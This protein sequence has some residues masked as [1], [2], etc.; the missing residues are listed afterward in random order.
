[1]I[2]QSAF[3]EFAGHHGAHNVLFHHADGNA[4][5]LGD[6][7]VAAFVE[8][9]QHKG[10]SATGWQGLDGGHVGAND[11]LRGKLLFRLQL[12]RRPRELVL[13]KGVKIV[14]LAYFGTSVLING[15]VARNA[16]QQ[17]SHVQNRLTSRL[18]RKHAQ[19]AFLG[20]VFCSVSVF[21]LLGQK[22]QQFAVVALE[23]GRGTRKPL[24]RQT[25]EAGNCQGR[26]KQD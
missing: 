17:R 3:A 1:M 5:L 7:G 12:Q 11:L 18:C 24:R 14:V 10:L 15:K 2:A 6:L 26:I 25:C 13:G 21:D 8:H 16:V 19:A 4:H 20:Q 9:L 22:V 23:H